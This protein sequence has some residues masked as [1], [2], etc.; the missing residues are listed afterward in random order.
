MTNFNVLYSDNARDFARWTDAWNRWPER[1]VFAHPNYLRLFGSGGDHAVC[2]LLQSKHGTVLYPFFLRDVPT[3]DLVDLDHRGARD[4]ISPYGYGGAVCFEINDK[5]TLTKEFWSL[6]DAWCLNTNV[7]SEFVRFSLFSDSLLDFP[8]VVETKQDNIV[9]SLDLDPGD[10]WMDFDHKVRKNVKKAQRLGVVT[11]IDPEGKFFDDFYRIY[12]K[13]M[14]RRA[15]SSS[16]YFSEDFF[17][18]IHSTL[19]GQFAYFHARHEGRIV[20]TELVLLSEENVYSFLG[21]TESAAFDMRP[22]DL[23][24]YEIMT[25]AAAS[26]KRRFV[27]GGGY[28]PDDGIYKYKKAFA[29]SGV[30]PFRVGRRISNPAAYDSLVEARLA[31]SVA[32]VDSGL[33]EGFF[34]AYRG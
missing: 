1:E 11:E 4:L 14:D 32:S 28:V 25:W 6:F 8:G 3:E 16:Y 22:N 31:R 19:P 9:R 18:A 20:S 33:E 5:A 30:V 2:A 12:T 27:L 34:P 13:T 17:R 24:K 15:A 26:G 21:G 10:L 29:P 7:V 23:L